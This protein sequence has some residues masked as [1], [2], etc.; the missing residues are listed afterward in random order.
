MYVCDYVKIS[1]PIY[2]YVYTN[3]RIRVY[4]NGDSLSSVSLGS[5]YEMNGHLLIC[6]LLDF[7]AGVNTVEF[8]VQKFSLLLLS[9]SFLHLFHGS[10]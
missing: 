8:L 5:L 7:S 1:I 6:V 10:F 3:I 2:I 9:S 4:T